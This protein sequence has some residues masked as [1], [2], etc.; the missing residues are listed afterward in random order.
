MKVLQILCVSF[1]LFATSTHAAEFI[2]GLDDIPLMPQ[3]TQLHSNNIT[4][5]N[6]ESR[7]SEAYI[8]SEKN[9]FKNIADFYKKTLPQLGWKFV[10]NKENALH[11]ERDME[12]LDIVLEKSKPLLVRVTLKSK[13]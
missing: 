5:G 2:D 11:F 7:F 8:S 1:M 6:D 10:S 13:D 3:T 12:V 9:K 4:F